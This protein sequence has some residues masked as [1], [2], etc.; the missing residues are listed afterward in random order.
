MGLL[1]NQ[2]QLAFAKYGVDTSE[3]QWSGRPCQGL[4]LRS[5]DWFVIPVGLVVVC[6][7]LLPV[8]D[9]LQARGPNSW[10]PQLLAILLLAL[11]LAVLF[12]RLFWDAYKRGATYYALTADSAL[13]LRRGL[14]GGIQ[15]VFLPTVQTLNYSPSANGTGTILFGNS[16]PWYSRMDMSTEPSVPAFEG[17]ADAFRVYDLCL[18]AQRSDYSDTFGFGGARFRGTR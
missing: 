13:I 8:S 17:V 16:T 15:R 4:I 5:G 12:G 10:V 9:M 18:R 3:I 14:G 2:A 11:V 7:L 6:S 1:I